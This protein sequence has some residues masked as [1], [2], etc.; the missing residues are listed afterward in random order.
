MPVTTKFNT[1][2]KRK[3]DMAMIYVKSK[4]GRAAFFQGKIIPEDKFVAV[5]DDPYIRRLANHW[6][7]IEIQG[8]NR[9]KA[10]A[11]TYAKPAAKTDS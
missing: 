11:K 9:S 3:P 2:P 4:P 1:P 6:E 7:D 10:A 5:T 8:D